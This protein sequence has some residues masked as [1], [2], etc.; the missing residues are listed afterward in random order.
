MSVN[1]TA[2][3]KVGLEARDVAKVLAILEG[4]TPSKKDIG[5]SWH[6]CIVTEVDPKP[7]I[8]AT[9]DIIGHGEI[10]TG[11][12]KDC[13]SDWFHASIRHNNKVYAAVTGGSTVRR[14]ARLNR[15]VD[16]F[17]GFVLAQDGKVTRQRSK[18][19]APLDRW[20]LVPVSNKG[21]G[22]YQAA[23]MNLMPINE[24]DIAEARGQAAYKGD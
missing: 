16:W 8:I 1:A 3:L 20:G 12:A 10:G 13:A 17:G 4:A 22:A 23:L 9:K 11:T 7:K 18:P 6:P 15:L 5:N 24:D 21:W 19:Q 14:V 2:Y